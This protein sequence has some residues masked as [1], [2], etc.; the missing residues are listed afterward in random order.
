[1]GLLGGVSNQSAGVEW[2]ARV[3]LPGGVVRTGELEWNL[4]VGMCA[5][6]SVYMH[7][8]QWSGVVVRQVS[9]DSTERF[10][11]L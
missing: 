3:G 9:Q 6:Q 2:R 8:V 7:G 4:V 11:E 5:F 1:M 10:L